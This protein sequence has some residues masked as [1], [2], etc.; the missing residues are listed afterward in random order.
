MSQSHIIICHYLHIV[1]IIRANVGP[2]NVSRFSHV[3]S[4]E[5][6]L[7][8]VCS[9]TNVPPTRITWTKDELPIDI[10]RDTVRMKQTVTDYYNSH[11][12]NTLLIN[13]NPDNVVG[14]YACIVSNN[15]GSI[16]SSTVSIAGI[17]TVL[18]S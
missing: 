18:L 13:N 10:D 3:T 1:T 11:Y 7:T 16:T 6:S 9:T 4:Q 5:S 8:F 15:F 17:I 12:D 14:K 2:P